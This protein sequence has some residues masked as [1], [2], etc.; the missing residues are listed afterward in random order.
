M[1]DIEENDMITCDSCGK[2]YHPSQKLEHDYRCKGEDY[3][4]QLNPKIMEMLAEVKENFEREDDLEEG[5]MICFLCRG[6]FLEEVKLEHFYECGSNHISHLMGIVNQ[7]RDRMDKLEQDVY[8]L[9][10]R[11][12]R[13]DQE[14]EIKYGGRKRY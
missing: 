8:H 11:N 14:K 7:L 1:S 2:R 3:Y 9:E 13:K 4:L 6:I 12:K 5:Q 10:G